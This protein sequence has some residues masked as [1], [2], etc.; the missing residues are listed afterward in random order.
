M[1]VYEYG[2]INGGSKHLI[3]MGGGKPI[4]KLE[5]YGCVLGCCFFMVI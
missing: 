2:Y 1:I 4:V 5:V 3:G